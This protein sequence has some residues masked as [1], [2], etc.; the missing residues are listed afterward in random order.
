MAYVRKGSASSLEA[1]S[2]V[3]AA[4]FLAAALMGAAHTRTAGLALALATVAGL[5]TYMARAYGRSQK[6][7][8]HGALAAAS[9]ALGAG[10]VWALLC[11]ARGVAA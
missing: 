5:G 6:V 2:A 1:S 10:Y 8:P 7:M 11:V 3:A 9:A 4:L